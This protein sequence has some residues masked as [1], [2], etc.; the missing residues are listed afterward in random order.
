MV[1]FATLKKNRT[2]DLDKI[3][4]QIKKINSSDAPGQD[5][6]YWQPTVD[7]VG[8]GVATIR[9]LPPPGEEDVPFVRLWNHAFKGKSGVWYIEDSLTTIGKP[10]PV[11]E[12]NGTLWNSTSDDE[13]PAR[14]Q[15]R[16][17]KRKLNYIS[18]IYVVSD[19]AAPE[20]EGKVFLYK[21]GK[22]IFEKVNEAM[23]P[24][25]ADEVAFNPFDLW[26]GANFKI[27]IRK[28]E[29]YRNYD[30]SEFDKPG[31]LFKSDAE[32]EKVWKVEHSLQALIAPSAFKDYDT[33]K[34]KL[35]NVLGLTAQA[36]QRVREDTQTAAPREERTV[37]EPRQATNAPPW[38]PTE[39]DGEE[40]PDI[41]F[42]KSL[43]S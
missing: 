25:F 32:L 6:R 5:S 12:Y 27:K 17:Q 11:S 31:P 41:A 7:K 18:N 14:K 13:S 26:G 23:N 20:N 3:N 8:N 42:F 35:N 16:S 38:E 10:D 4:E 40:D 28:V 29:G 30:K 15:A 33:L 1:D 36:V 34:A 9:F 43:A 39:G 19:P 37:R 2:N 22:K 21:Y 24:Q